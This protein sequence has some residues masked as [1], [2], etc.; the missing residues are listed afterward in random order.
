[1][2][3]RL[4]ALIPSYT[5]CFMSIQLHFPGW[6]WVQSIAFDPSPTD[7]FLNPETS[8]SCHSLWLVAVWTT[9]IITDSHRQSKFSL[10]FLLLAVLHNIGEIWVKSA[11]GC[12]THCDCWMPGRVSK[13]CGSR[14][15]PWC[16]CSNAGSS[17]L[18]TTAAWLCKWTCVSSVMWGQALTVKWWHCIERWSVR[19]MALQ[20]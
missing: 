18:Q 5:I 7:W 15:S 4:W 6:G 13:P 20:N 12:T 9:Q 8:P 10:A 2:N 19:L 17:W 11:D 3:G 1:M 14:I 16:R